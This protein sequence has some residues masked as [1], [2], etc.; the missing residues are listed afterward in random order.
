VK[1]VA[2]AVLVLLAGLT[3][4]A[5]GADAEVANPRGTT[6]S[7]PEGKTLRY[8][9]LIEESAVG[10]LVPNTLAPDLEDGDTP[11][12]VYNTTSFGPQ[13]DDLFGDYEAASVVNLQLGGSATPRPPSRRPATSSRTASPRVPR[14]VS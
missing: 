13:D 1:R 8:S 6:G 10:S 11:A 2:G 3:A 12:A 5:L 9:A 14:P 4:G 7:S